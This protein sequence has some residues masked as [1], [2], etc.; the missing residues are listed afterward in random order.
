MSF[1]GKRSEFERQELLRFAESSSVKKTSARC[2]FDSVI[3]T[4]SNWPKFTEEPGSTKRILSE[5]DGRIERNLV[6]SS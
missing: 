6:N 3:A 4:V 5:L 1:V 2:V